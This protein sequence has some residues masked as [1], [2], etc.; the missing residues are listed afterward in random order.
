M[1]LKFDTRRVGLAIS[2]AVDSIAYEYGKVADFNLLFFEGSSSRELIGISAA[3]AH[4]RHKATVFIGP[5]S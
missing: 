1:F 4:Y 5:G 3:K 2:L